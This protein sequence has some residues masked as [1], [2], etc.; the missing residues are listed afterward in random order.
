MITLGCFTSAA[1]SQDIVRDTAAAGAPDSTARLLQSIE[2]VGRKVRN[3][4]SD[5]SFAAT[6][7]AELNR[8]IPQSISTVTK[9]LMADRQAFQLADALRG[10]S[11]VIP[12]SYYNQFTIRGIS[13]NEEG[14][15]INGMRTRQYYF[16]QPLTN[17]IERVEVIK[18]PASTTFSSVDPGG[19]INLVTKKPLATDRKEI[20][21]SAGSFSTMRGT[22]DFTG[23]VNKSRTLLYRLNAGYL[24]TRSFRDLQF[25]K[26]LLISPSLTYVP[27]DRT[28]L[29]VEMIYSNIHTRL[30]RGQAIF[31]AI[32]GKTDLLST[33]ISFN[34]GATNDYFKS[35][36][37]ILM[38]NMAHRLS[39]GITFNIAYMK[40]TWTEDLLEHRTTN[41]F[42]VD[43]NNQPIP[44]LAAMQ[45]VQRQQ[46]WNT[47]NVSSYFNFQAR[48][49]ALQH[50][51]LIGY[52]HN[53][54]HK[55]EGGGQ[56]AARGY[57]LASGQTAATYDPARQQE[58][59]VITRNGIQM[60]KPNVEHFDLQNPVHTI[61]NI[62]EYTFSKAAL[63]AG[64]YRVHAAY[65]QEQ[66]KWKQFTLLLGLRQEW[67]QDVTNYKTDRAIT[68][69]QSR[70][71]PR[72]GLVYALLPNMN[73]YATYLQGYQPQSNTV[74][75]VPVPAPA[76]S[77]YDPLISDLKE[78]GIKSE[79]LDNQ[80]QLTLALYEI[81]QKNIL[82][83]A[84]DPADPD[85]LVTRGAERSRGLDLDITGFVQRNWQVT[86][87]YSYIDARI[88]NDNNKALI[89]ARKQNTPIH[90]A[91]LWT[92]YNFSSVPLLKDLGLGLG[93]QYSGDKVPWF[94]RDFM[95]PAYTL[96]D[97]AL[98]YTPG[99][100]NVQLALN[101]NNLANKTYWIGAQNYQRLFPGAPRN[102][103]LGATCKF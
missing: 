76:G 99:K 84:N 7:T 46:F 28:T 71:L 62:N 37:V 60:P 32:A 11:G 75:L 50:K 27:N 58:Y 53:S 35:R 91:N 73:V 41:A 1:Q 12:A 74:T 81:N 6:K 43:I 48:T 65:V 2:V 61:K 85:L 70:L 21:V 40:Q 4:Q 16:A 54:T 13:Q 44:T 52:D 95:V 30:D 82:M 33:P 26:A 94:I 36:E 90:S 103:M 92:R 79:W 57:L 17:N 55:H 20:S 98:Y 68:V 45:V 39:G 38:G 34:I 67:Y 42:A 72:I 88:M 89:G 77:N 87:S 64:L 14:T 24:D 18:G 31:G 8:N 97:A 100:S 19:S 63:P 9:E 22:L 102:V 47:D 3:Y 56:N 51:L 25:Q 96:L 49:G 101:V 78:A 86:A 23:P 93:V 10:T 59:Q 83:N 66:A 69:Q 29:N 15:I 5:Y 80:L